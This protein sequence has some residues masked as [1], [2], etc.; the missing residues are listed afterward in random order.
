MQR[1]HYKI[2][3]AYPEL[4]EGDDPLLT[5]HD[6]ERQQTFLTDEAPALMKDY[7]DY[8][9]TY[10]YDHYYNADHHEASEYD[11]FFMPGTCDRTFVASS[12]IATDFTLRRD[13]ITQ[14][15]AIRAVLDPCASLVVQAH[16]G[17]TVKQ[18][19]RMNYSEA[20]RDMLANG[21][22]APITGRIKTT[23]NKENLRQTKIHAFGSS[24]GATIVNGLAADIP[25]IRSLTTLEA[26][27]LK[28]RGIWDFAKDMGRSGP[29]F[30]ENYRLG[31]L[32]TKTPLLHQGPETFS[33]WLA[34]LSL[35]GNLATVRS[36]GHATHTAHLLDAMRKN[37]N[38]GVMRA[39]AAN[40][41]ISPAAEN[42][43]ITTFIQSHPDVKRPF[44][45]EEFELTSELASHNS[46][47]I[48]ILLTAL[49]KRAMRLGEMIK[50]T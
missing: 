5:W 48:P 11:M 13:R 6:V 33:Y 22:L 39:W 29:H 26:P 12:E 1:P 42:R 38:M 27:N 40:S 19:S 9:K 21:D 14:A 35:P 45:L 2:E 50:T 18:R 7:R 16:G 41:L 17:L 32:E 47:N 44:K 43:Q 37:P 30:L 4:F 10:D 36:L 25:S 8:I 49:V 24:A 31:K 20:E 34:S 28:D 15:L 23:L 46:S 3:K